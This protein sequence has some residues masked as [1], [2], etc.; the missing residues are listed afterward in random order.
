MLEVSLKSTRHRK[1]FGVICN[2]INLYSKDEE[3]YKKLV[4]E[5]YNRYD[6]YL[7]MLKDDAIN[8]PEVIDAGV[9]TNY[10]GSKVEEEEV[11]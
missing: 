7:I 4:G 11:N 8:V 10:D 3:E 9:L 5:L 1:N 6:N 2:F